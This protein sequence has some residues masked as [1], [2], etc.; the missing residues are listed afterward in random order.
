MKYLLNAT[1]IGLILGAI[2][3]VSVFAQ[4]TEAAPGITRSEALTTQ[5]RS[6]ERTSNST[7]PSTPAYSQQSLDSVAGTLSGK[8][9]PD[10][11]NPLNSILPTGLTRVR[12]ESPLAS[13]I[14]SPIDFF[15]VPPPNGGVRVDLQR[16]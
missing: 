1:A 14:R 4:T 5:P 12:S 8:P 16:F 6:V 11:T 7:Q 15:Q 10:P 9:K 13:D 2:V 3:P